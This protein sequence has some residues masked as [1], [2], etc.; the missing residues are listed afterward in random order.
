MTPSHPIPA[1]VRLPSDR[2]ASGRDFG[3]EELE[4]L[5]RVLA[6]GVLNSTGG[7]AVRELETAFGAE[8]GRPTVACSS[9]T[10]AVHAA[11]AALGLQPGD[12]V[13]TSPVTD[14]GAIVPIVYEGALPRFA[15]VDP[16]TLSV[17][18]ES[19]ARATTAR[20]RAILVTHLFGRPCDVAAIARLA[21][22]RGLVLIEDCAQAF[23][24]ASAAGAV[25][26]F[27]T[28]ACFSLQQGKHM[29]CGEGGLVV[30]ADDAAADRVRRF[31]NKGWGYGD[32]APDHDRPGLNYRMSELQGAVA[33]AQFAKLGSVVERRRRSAAR[34]TAA[35]DG[36][37]GLDLMREAPSERCSYWRYNLHVDPAIHAGGPDALADKLRAAGIGSQPGYVRRPAFACGLFRTWRTH[38]VLR[39]AV[40]GAGLEQAPWEGLDAATHP[41]TYRGLQ[42]VLVLPWNEAFDEGHV[43][44]LAGAVRAGLGL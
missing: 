6:S 32:A 33:L 39:L 22:E 24:A 20:T 7:R 1:P 31:V 38:T 11:L 23:R 26:T 8:F 14:M 5:E 35:L 15:D 36:I 43:D 18:A 27:G 13:V 30:A 25:G 44:A 2:D 41:G 9:G 10:A 40:Q 21:R 16:R 17:T 42:T 37:P 4:Q 12:E 28:F 34:F 29:T 19:V 3:R